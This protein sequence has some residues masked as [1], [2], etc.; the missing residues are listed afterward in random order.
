MA[1]GLQ[2]E[3]WT[4]PTGVYED[5]LIFP[6]L[7]YFILDVEEREVSTSTDHRSVHNESCSRS[8]SISQLKQRGRHK[9]T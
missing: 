7:G 2:V 9:H 1:E 4:Y 6:M 8:E 3:G 5:K